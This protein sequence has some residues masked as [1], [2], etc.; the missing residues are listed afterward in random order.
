MGYNVIIIQ[1]LRVGGIFVWYLWYFMSFLPHMKRER[2]GQNLDISIT[3]EVC[4]LFSIHLL[5]VGFSYWL[6][7]I[8]HRSTGS[9]D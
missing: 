4:F 1:V 6:L 9:A 2:P 5:I 8:V 7:L 3:S